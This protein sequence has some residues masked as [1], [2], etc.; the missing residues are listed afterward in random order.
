MV[1]RI[2]PLVQ[3]TP[4]KKAF[5]EEIR[6]S[7]LPSAQS[8]DKICEPPPLEPATTMTLDSDKGNNSTSQFGGSD[9]TIKIHD[10]CYNRCVGLF[11]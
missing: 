5:T 10:R 2:E 9:E 11:L 6:K 1:I 4:Y 3:N 7:N 8:I